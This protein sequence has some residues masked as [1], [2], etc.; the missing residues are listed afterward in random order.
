M[1]KICFVATIPAAVNSFLRDHIQAAGEIYS[2]T[3]VCNSE[4]KYL[5]EGLDAQ[6]IFLPI[7]RK[8]SLLKD[9]LALILLV[10]LFRQEKFD[11]V[12]SHL[13][14]TG[15]LG[16]IA[17]SLACVPIRINTFHG[18]VWATQSGWRR[19]A[20]KLC[21][22]L[23]GLLATNILVVSPSQQAFLVKEGILRQGKAKVIGAGSICGVNPLRFHTDLD[24]RLTV[25]KNLG[26]TQEATVILFLGRLNRDKGILDLASAFD[27]IS[28]H[29][30]NVVL[31]LVGS[32][33]EVAFS[34]IQ[35]ICHSEL[36]RL[37]YVT[38]TTTPE[39]YMAAADI[40]CLPSYREGLPMT[41]LE[42][43]ACG[44]ST[45]ASRIYGITDAV[46]EGKTGLLFTAGD[47]SGLTQSLSTLIEDKSL[48]LQMGEA[49]RLRVLDL[50]PAH[51]I[52]EGVLAFYAELLAERYGD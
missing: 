23:V 2:V 24:A 35:E 40:F 7:E 21:D 51:K 18:E 16:V 25:R 6:I 10:K 32:E 29:H 52:I 48:R 49:A 15:L 36:D 1:K 27:V 22:K 43:A 14:K 50:F 31:L 13:P 19:R 41:I 42:S 33:E 9:L 38:F 4:D 30:L 20:L 8:P 45:V 28:K 44:V 39:H 12:H 37:H 26:V 47:I 17:A 11:I 3:V 5:L 34:Q 46:E